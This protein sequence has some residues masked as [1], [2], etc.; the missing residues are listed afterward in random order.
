MKVRRIAALLAVSL[1]VGCSGTA[2]S[3]DKPTVRILATGGTIAGAAREST[4][5]GY[6]SGAVGVD[7]LIEAVPQMKEI[8]DVSGEQIAS[9]GSQDM[10]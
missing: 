4:D 6:K 8:A 7:V 1:L 9:I 10:N 2:Q 5:A 3:A